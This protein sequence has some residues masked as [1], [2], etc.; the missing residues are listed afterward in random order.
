VCQDHI[1][2]SG[3][4]LFHLTESPLSYLKAMHTALESFLHVFRFI[5]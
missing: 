1:V 5:A 4:S 2:I 3:D